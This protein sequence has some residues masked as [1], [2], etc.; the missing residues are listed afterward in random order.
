MRRG[1]FWSRTAVWMQRRDINLE[2]PPATSSLQADCSM[3]ASAAGSSCRGSPPAGRAA[4]QGHI[5]LPAGVDVRLP[6][7]FGL[8]RKL[9][10]D[11]ALAFE[12]M[13]EQHELS[14]GKFQRI[15]V[16]ARLVHVH[17]P[18]FGRPGEAAAWSS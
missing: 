2:R 11:R 12:K 17:L 4:G 13:P 14:V 15:M 3:S 9:Q 5:A 8:R 16:R 6:F 1:P 18:E 7:F 10:H